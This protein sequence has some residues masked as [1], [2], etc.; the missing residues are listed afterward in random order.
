MSADRAQLL[1]ELKSVKEPAAQ[2]TVQT[3]DMGIEYEVA[4]AEGADVVVGRYGAWP[5]FGPFAI[6]SE[7]LQ[8]LER[9]RVEETLPEGAFDGTAIEY[10]GQPIT[11]CVKFNELAETEAIKLVAT[12]IERILE[13]LGGQP[14]TIYV[15]FHLFEQTAPIVFTSRSALV[16]HFMASESLQPWD[17]MTTEE[18]LGWSN[19]VAEMKEFALN[20]PVPSAHGADLQ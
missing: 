6:F 13:A 14:G 5:A 20:G 18:L 4:S 11:K 16:A 7:D 1:A 15:F 9:C 10:L 12:F 3:M 2:P 8:R 17:N 19:R